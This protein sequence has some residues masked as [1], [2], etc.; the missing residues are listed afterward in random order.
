[1]RRKA[2]LHEAK[3]NLSKLIELVQCGEEVIICKAGKPVAKLIPYQE[4]TQLR[5]PGG[6][7]NKMEM[8]EDFDELP[9]E[10]MRYFK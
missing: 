10:F 3:T 8:R 6:W 7:E 2:N 1:M 9:A 4:S 5:V